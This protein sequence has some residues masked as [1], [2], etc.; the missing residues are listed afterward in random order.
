[1]D[2][3]TMLERIRGDDTASPKIR[4]TERSDHIIHVLL[5]LVVASAIFLF[6]IKVY[7]HPV[8]VSG[9][10]MEPTYHDGQMLRT[11]C[12]VTRK[13]VRRGSVICF[14]HDG[15]K[16][17]KRVIAVPGDR[18]SF[19]DGYAYIN[20]K[21]LED[22]FDEMKVFPEKEIVLSAD[23]YYVLGDNRNDSTDSRVFGAVEFTDI[24]AVVNET[25]DYYA[26]M[27]QNF[28]ETKDKL[29]EL[30]SMDIEKMKGDT[31]GDKELQNEDDDARAE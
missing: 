3:K 1:M 8:I 15:Q 14:T 26:R 30:K 18:V 27:A 13:E 22:G 23:Q 7:M 6:V 11:D 24:T 2:E 10:S 4:D 25:S 29:E 28:G 9:S 20:G 17:V 16:L 5:I 19:R 12:L 21:K 31:Y